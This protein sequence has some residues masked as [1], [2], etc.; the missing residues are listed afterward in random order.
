MTNLE[1]TKLEK[2][3][4][5]T[6][7]GLQKII[8]RIK[9][10]FESKGAKYQRKY[11][12]YILSIYADEKKKQDKKQK[13]KKLESN[14]K[15]NFNGIKNIVIKKRASVII[16]LKKEGKGGLRISKEILK[17]YNEKVCKDT[18]NKFLKNNTDYLK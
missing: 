14:K 18:V 15:Y 13:T 10:L 4:N 6:S 9:G 17:T 8:T 11:Y 12:Y 5:L 7:E 16:E 2:E 1:L 3:L